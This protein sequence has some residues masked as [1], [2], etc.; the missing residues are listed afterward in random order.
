L[1]VAAANLEEVNIKEGDTEDMFEKNEQVSPLPS[2]L[3]FPLPLSRSRCAPPRARGATG[4]CGAWGDVR[5]GGRGRS[6][7]PGPEILEPPRTRC[8]DT[9]S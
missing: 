2:G 9:C 4:A 6:A 7:S 5:V 8:E 1:W 3:G